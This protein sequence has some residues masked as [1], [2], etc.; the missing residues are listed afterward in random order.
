MTAHLVGERAMSR[1]SNMES[2]DDRSAKRHRPD[3]GYDTGDGLSFL[4]TDEVHVVQ[5]L[6][7]CALCHIDAAIVPHSSSVHGNNEALRRIMAMTVAMAGNKR[8]EIVYRRMAEE[9]NNTC[10][11]QMAL[12]GHECQKWTP[13]MVAT[14]MEKHVPLVPRLLLQRYVGIMDDIIRTSHEAY[15]LNLGEEDGTAG[16]K[17][18]ADMIMNSLKVQMPLIASYRSCIA[19]DAVASGCDLLWTQ[20]LN[21]AEKDDGHEQLM[22]AMYQNKS[23]AGP[24]D[25]PTASTLFDAI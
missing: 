18:H 11:R 13:Q 23:T 12:H 5:P 2:D 3:E 16:S 19:E 22:I 25:R 14:H 15:F 10:W 7:E 1:E 4:Q 24:N 20:T 8:N 17:K 6:E 9:F 21:E